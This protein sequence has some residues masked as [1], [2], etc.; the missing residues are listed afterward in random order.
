MKTN[1]TELLK[2]RR[3]IYHLGKKVSL[4]NNK[5]TNLIKEAVKESPSSFNSQT[6]RVVI[7]FEDQ[8]LKLWEIVEENL[9]NVVPTEE[10][11][12]ATQEKIDSFRAG[13]GT[14]LFYEDEEVV[15]GLQENFSLYADNFPLWSEQSSGI[16]SVNVWTA[17]AE[18]EIG[19]SLQ[20]YNPLIDNDVQNEW[21]LPSTWKLRAQMPFGSIETPA[22][23]KTYM[24]DEERF[25]IFE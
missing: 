3:S 8:H 17:L 21:D 14:I 13:Y 18:N 2:N 6:S 1:T 16:V 12:Q 25:R 5:I 19:A 4:E 10:A 23:E 22:E 7:L 20:H 9:R 24:D 11:F 15:R